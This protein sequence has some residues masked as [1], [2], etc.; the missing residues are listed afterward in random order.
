VFIETFILQLLFFIA[1]VRVKDVGS[2]KKYDMHV[3]TIHSRCSYHKLKDVLKEARSKKLNG[4]AI[5]DHNKIKGALSLKRMNDKLNK[6]HNTDFEVIVGEEIMTPYGEVLAYNLT[7]EIRPGRFHDVLELIKNQG[8]F[9]SIAH[10]YDF[11]RTPYSLKK[12]VTAIE[13]F[14]GRA[15]VFPNIKAKNVAIKNQIPQTGGSD[16][17]LPGEIGRGFTLFSGDIRHALKKR[18]TMTS[19]NVL[20][21]LDSYTRA[22]YHRAKGNLCFGRKF[23]QEEMQKISTASYK[24]K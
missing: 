23:Y 3:H 2:L 14:N 19:G 9:A 5:T 24:I 20:G 16:A 15:A 21:F 8:A 6:K 11:I 22:L 4:I 17:H 1:T 13:S 7:E 10:P 18:K 12:Y